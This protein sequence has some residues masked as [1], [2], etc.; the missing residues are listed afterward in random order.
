M[1]KSRLPAAVVSVTTQ[2]QRKGKSWTARNYDLTSFSSIE[3]FLEFATADS[4]KAFKEQPND[5]KLVYTG[6]YSNIYPY[7]FY[8]KYG[9][10]WEL[11]DILAGELP[12]EQLAML[13]AYLTL[14]ND[15]KDDSL[16]AA[17]INAGY[18]YIGRFE[19][20]I[21]LIEHCY[22]NDP[23]TLFDYLTEQQRETFYHGE[24]C[25][26]VELLSSVSRLKKLNGYYFHE[27]GASRFYEQL[28][29]LQALNN[30]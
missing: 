9:I 26:P 24:D 10:C 22:L 1:N 29:Q 13:D 14:F 2:K 20:D 6:F 25:D 28:S 21:E 3:D 17:L 23:D 15:P 11:F 4:A 7:S 8:A 27:R 19:S 30:K 12:A 5:I 18:A 16:N